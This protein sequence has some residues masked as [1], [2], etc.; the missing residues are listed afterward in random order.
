V[1]APFAVDLDGRRPCFRIRA[2]AQ[3]SGR[4]EVLPM[5][6][7]FAVFLMDTPPA[8]RS[9][10]VFPLTWKTGRVLRN[11]PCIGVI[12]SLFG[13]KA[14]VVVNKAEGK[15]ASAHDFRRSFGTRWAKRVK[16]LVLKRLMRHASIGTTERYYVDLD[17]DEVA[18][19]LWANYAPTD[20]N[21]PALGN[22]PGNISPNSTLDHAQRNDR[23]PLWN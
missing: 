5:T 17:S 6:P 12:V 16:P 23:K 14:G 18:D 7:D 4:D 19:E 20:G 1:E 15:F 13:R 11:Q 10:K 8:E 3:K 21:T 22:K 2:E 9:G